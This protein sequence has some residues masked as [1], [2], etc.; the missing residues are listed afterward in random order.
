MGHVSEHIFDANIPN[1]NFVV[2]YLINLLSKAF[3]HLNK[4]QIETFCLA[5]FNK[6]Y[7]FGQFKVTI[8]DFLT[9][10]KSFSGDN[11][12]LFEEEKKVKLV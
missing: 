6:C 7:N 4:L 5:L 12:D 9:T 3:S 8:R 11:D 2:N 10:L 1:K